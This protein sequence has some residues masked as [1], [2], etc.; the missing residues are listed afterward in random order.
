MFL[1]VT[2]THANRPSTCNA[3]ACECKP[4]P[5]GTPVVWTVSTYRG[6]TLSRVWHPECFERAT[7]Y[8]PYYHRLKAIREG[9]DILPLPLSA[10]CPETGKVIGYE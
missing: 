6:R 3:R 10:Y 2:Q 5:K 4:I 7:A 1:R 8:A 9:K